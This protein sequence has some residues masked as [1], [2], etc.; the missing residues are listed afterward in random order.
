MF[1]RL[2]E[3]QKRFGGDLSPNVYSFEAQ[4]NP[5]AL[6]CF[7]DIE[8]DLEGVDPSSWDLLKSEAGPLLT[9]KDELRGWRALF[10]K[11]N[12]AKGYQY[13]RHIGCTNVRFIPRSTRRGMK[14]P[15]IEGSLGSIR[16]LCEVKT[17]NISEDEVRA[18]NNSSVKSILTELPAGFFTKFR[19]TLEVARCQMEE[20]CP[21]P[22][23]KMVVY[24][25]IN[26]DDILHE[27]VP[28]YSPQIRAFITTSPVRG[29]EV[30]LDIKPPFYYAMSH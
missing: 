10:D 7:R 19:S 30:I 18:R 15:D 16:V 8:A 21:G 1:P 5:I 2:R 23:V 24:V 12:E 27:Y 20:Y 6:K 25:I 29:I 13:L 3:L 11:L 28:N 22:D 17:I 26:F 4:D 14:T 9:Q